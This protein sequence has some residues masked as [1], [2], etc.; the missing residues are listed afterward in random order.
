MIRKTTR[1]FAPRYRRCGFPNFRQRMQRLC[2]AVK[3][4]DPAD[5]RQ[6]VL[7]ILQVWELGAAYHWP[8]WRRR[9]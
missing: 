7:L 2:A 3:R 1:S 4:C 5:R 6:K 9:V 8:A